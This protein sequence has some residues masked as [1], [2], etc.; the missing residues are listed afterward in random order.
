MGHDSVSG[1]NRLPSNRESRA[2]G[3]SF[4]EGVTERTGL[5]HGGALRQADVRQDRT[6]LQAGGHAEELDIFFG[7]VCMR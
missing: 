5:L 1:T 6:H 3:H 2:T 4:A 7:G